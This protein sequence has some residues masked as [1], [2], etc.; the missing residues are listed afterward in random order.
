MSSTNLG[1]IRCLC[2]C[3][4][5]NGCIATQVSSND[6]GQLCGDGTCNQGTCS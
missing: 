5:G 6:I 3:C 1:S 4:K 2:K